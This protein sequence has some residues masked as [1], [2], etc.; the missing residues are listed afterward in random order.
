MS[1]KYPVGIAY[2]EG[3]PGSGHHGHSGRPGA[4][5]GSVS[6][7]VLQGSPK[8][9]KWANDIRRKKLDALDSEEEKTLQD[10]KKARAAGK[11][12]AADMEEQITVQYTKARANL[13]RVT[14]AK[15]WIDRRNDSTRQIGRFG[16]LGPLPGVVIKKQDS[17]PAKEPRKH[18]PISISSE[19]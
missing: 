2:Q 8:Q 18:R 14:S 19:P 7:A 1:E 10:T 16:L 3:G 6:G 9:V 12:V 11:N 13:Q 17:K 15:W 4:V 5:G